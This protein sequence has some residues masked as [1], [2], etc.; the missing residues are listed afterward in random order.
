[1]QLFE[2]YRPK[3]L[4]EVIGLGSIVQTLQALLARGFNGGAFY[5]IGKSGTGKT[6]LAQVLCNEL[7]V[8]PFDV[9]EIGG[10]DCSIEFVRETVDNFALGAWGEAG[11]K[12][13]I[14]NESQAIA[15]RAIQGLL[16]FLETLPKKRL[17]VFTT[18]EH[19]DANIFG[20]YTAPMASRCKVFKLKPDEEECAI[21]LAISAQAEN[22]NAQP[23]EGFRHLLAS[24]DGNL[25]MAFQRIESGEMLKPLSPDA[26]P[27]LTHEQLEAEK[28]ARLAE[29]I[30][31]QQRLVKEKERNRFLKKEAEENLRKKVLEAMNAKGSITVAEVAAITQLIF[32]GAER[33]LNKLCADGLGKRTRGGAVP[34]GS[35]VVAMHSLRL[36]Q[37]HEK[38]VALVNST[39]ATSTQEIM[40]A[41][42]A[43]RSS[44]TLDLRLL[45]KD[46][47]LVKVGGGAVP[48]G[49]DPNLWLQNAAVPTPKAKS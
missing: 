31:T 7:N 4:S 32:T 8:D 16:P 41:C 15:P 29:K 3:R 46:G 2:K 5:F 36:K 49:S 45:S 22:L 48:A 11:W 23:I 28:E 24:C 27:Q 17:F 33:Y 6:T 47:R 14:V 39:A 13:V 12:V 25:R 18:T 21:H 42:K 40:E 19:L 26:V 30:A 37:R 38:I 34:I 43:S 44:V 9:T 35:E 1:M 20:E 10:A